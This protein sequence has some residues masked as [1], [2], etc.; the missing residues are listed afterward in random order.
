MIRPEELVVG[1][2]YRATPVIGGTQIDEVLQFQSWTCGISG[3]DPIKYSF[4]LMDR[5]H[6]IIQLGSWIL[7]NLK[8]DLA[9]QARVEIDEELRK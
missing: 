2:Y 4:V 1:R 7:R 6:P 9:Y 8:L 3:L 5:D